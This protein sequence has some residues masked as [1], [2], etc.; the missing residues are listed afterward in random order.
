MEIFDE[1]IS[2]SV[3]TI[4]EMI[5]AP[6]D[7]STLNSIFTTNS[8]EAGPIS[9]DSCESPPFDHTLNAPL[10]TKSSGDEEGDESSADVS[11][12]LQRAA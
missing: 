10:D 5:D 8:S 1:S 6:V 12:R 9:I 11:K 3:R 7:G 4:L 2:L